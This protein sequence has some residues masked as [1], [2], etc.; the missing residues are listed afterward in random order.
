MDS[1][2]TCKRTL[3]YGGMLEY[4]LDVFHVPCVGIVDG[5]LVGG[6]ARRFRSLGIP[7]HSC[8]FDAELSRNTLPSRNGLSHGLE[9]LV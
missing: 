2:W 7:I 6:R 3:R 5:V 9:Y 1:L 4:L 8:A